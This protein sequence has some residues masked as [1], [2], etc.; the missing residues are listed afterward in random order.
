MSIKARK[1]DTNQKIPSG[2]YEGTWDGYFVVINVNHEEVVLI[3][4]SGRRGSVRPCVVSVM[5]DEIFV[6]LKDLQDESSPQL[7]SSIDIHSST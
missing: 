2:V 5:D 4:R 6:S 3:A 7:F 1:Q